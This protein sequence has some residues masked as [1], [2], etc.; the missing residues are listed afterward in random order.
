MTYQIQKQTCQIRVTG[1]PS[2]ARFADAYAP[3]IE[4]IRINVKG[5]I[6]EPKQIFSHEIQIRQLVYVQHNWSRV[7]CV[8]KDSFEAVGFCKPDANFL[9][10]KK[11]PKV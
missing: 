7:V 3:K 8:P 5:C 1:Q 2:A 11:F 10:A 9:S 6:S 4:M